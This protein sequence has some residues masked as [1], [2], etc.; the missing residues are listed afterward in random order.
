MHHQL[1]SKEFN[2]VGVI[3]EQPLE[4]LEKLAFSLRA[5]FQ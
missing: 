2:H 5:L 4:K 3:Q 1:T